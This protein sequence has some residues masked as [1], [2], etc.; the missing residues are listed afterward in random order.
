MLAKR[1]AGNAPVPPGRR[2]RVYLN[3]L[4]FDRDTAGKEKEEEDE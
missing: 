1:L 4:V 2:A 3:R